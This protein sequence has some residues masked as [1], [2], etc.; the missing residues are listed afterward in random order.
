MNATAQVIFASAGTGKTYRLSS[1]FLQRLLLE[2]RA[3]RE[4]DPAGIL[5]TTFTR[6]A[7]AEISRRVLKRLAEAMSRAD[8]LERLG[9][10]AGLEG[11][12]QQECARALAALTRGIHRLSIGTMDSFFS[13][14]AKVLA[15]ELGLPEQ[16]QVI[17]EAQATELSAQVL[18]ELL[19]N[20]GAEL[21]Q[22]WKAASRGYASG[23]GTRLLSVL[24]AIR[25]ADL[26]PACE[27][28]LPAPKRMSAEEVEHWRAVVLAL[29][30]SG[31]KGDLKKQRTAQCLQPGRRWDEL[32]SDA[33][34]I[35]ELL[36]GKLEF[37]R[38]PVDPE[39]TLVPMLEQVR[40]AAQQVEEGR[41][42]GLRRLAALYNQ[43]RLDAGRRR[44]SL[45][46][47]EVLALVARGFLAQDESMGEDLYFR[48]DGS[49]QHL[50]FDEFQDTNRMQ[51]RF[52]APIISNLVAGDGHSLFAVGDP[53]QAIY[54]W[55][56][57]DTDIMR[58][59]VDEVQPDQESLEKSRRSSQAVL[60]AVDFFF[61]GLGVAATGLRGI[62]GT[63]LPQAVA[64]WMSNYPEQGHACH[65][66]DLDGQSRLWGLADEEAMQDKV[67][68]LVRERLGQGSA[69]V[70]VLLRR[71]QWVVDLQGKLRECGIDSSSEISGMLTDS[72]WVQAML[73]RIAWMEHPGHGLAKALAQVALPIAA[74][75]P[76]TL[77]AWRRCWVNEGPA[78]LLGSWMEELQSRVELGRHDRDLLGHLVVL[79]RGLERAGDVQPDELLREARATRVALRE[80]GGAKVRLLTIHASKGLEFDSVILADMELGL[81]LGDREGLPDLLEGPDGF[82]AVLPGSESLAQLMGER[83]GP[84]RESLRRQLM[85]ML[86][87]IYVGM[88]RARRH[89]D[90][91]VKLRNEEQL[92]GSPTPAL[93]LQRVFGNSGGADEAP[94]LLWSLDCAGD[95]GALP[96]APTTE[97]VQVNQPL[98]EVPPVASRL[99]RRAPSAQAHGAAQSLHW[100]VASG[101]DGRAALMGRAVHGWLAQWEWADDPAAPSSQEVLVLSKREWAGLDPEEAEAL[102]QRFCREVLPELKPMQQGHYQARWPQAAE[103]VVWRERPFALVQDKALWSGRFD[104]VVLAKDAAG[105]WLGAEIVDFKTDQ[106]AGQL[107]ERYQAQVD[108][109]REALSSLIGLAADAI[110]TCLCS[111]KLPTLAG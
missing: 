56:G 38:K 66:V 93:L 24:E 92:G 43:R 12:T 65:R 23:V 97:L 110:S 99:E 85:E 109:Y 82:S 87:L 17:S 9:A 31:A 41:R 50:A 108:A 53:K 69:E 71:R 39:C 29:P 36:E 30:L 10:D 91:V 86:S 27:G 22:A 75:E 20:Q 45:T 8:L 5:A 48:L 4:P 1:Y 111:C 26:G 7:A 6:G 62:A 51:Y 64:D 74:E 78:V 40:K 25:F 63:V 2:V 35:S 18:E 89:L 49:L 72:P 14:L 19:R 46:F 55:R 80:V 67:V 21:M 73:A 42:E 79:A 44:G 88:T 32:W 52:F 104:R 102:L 96:V 15:W 95:P 54:N 3:G 57:G 105:Q 101:D 94:D 103:L 90:M 98:G 13:K 106:D 59:L 84:Y 70:A 100:A 60:S 28:A 83:D 107:E 58:E 16:W 76:P 81:M 11:L 47:G 61:R 68:A 33:E 37:N 34:L 77:E